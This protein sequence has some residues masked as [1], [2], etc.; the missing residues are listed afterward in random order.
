MCQ[1]FGN[2]FDFVQDFVW[3]DLG[4]LVFDFIFIFIYMNFEGFFGDRF[5]REYVDLDFVVMFYVMGQCMMC[6]FDLM[7]SKVVMVSG[8]QCVFIEVDFII[9]MSQIMV[10]V[11]YLFVEFCMFGLQYLCIFYLVVFL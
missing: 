9:M 1:F 4:Y 10:V 5:V 6:G 2:I 11:G 3:L 8:F 7:S